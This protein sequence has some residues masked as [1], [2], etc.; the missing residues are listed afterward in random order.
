MAEPPKRPERTRVPAGPRAGPAQLRAAQAGREDAGGE[1]RVGR[2]PAHP[3][4]PLARV[5]ADRPRPRRG[6]RLRPRPGGRGLPGARPRPPAVRPQ[7]GVRPGRARGPRRP[8]GLRRLRGQ[9]PVPAPA[10]PPRAEGA[11]GRPE[12]HPRHPGRRAQVPVGRARRPRRPD[13][14]RRRRRRTSPCT[15]PP[16]TAP[17]S[18]T[19]PRSSGSATAPP[20][21]AAAWRPRSWTGPTTWPTRSTTWKTACTRGWS[22]SKT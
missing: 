5:R 7:R 16:S 11:R 3:A 10:H 13:R 17:T 19:S 1:G 2:L 22:R 12:P 14:P 6:A 20:A 4:D 15:C 21:A 9:R 8:A 18:P